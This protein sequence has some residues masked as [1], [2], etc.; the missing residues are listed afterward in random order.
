M[1]SFGG[2]FGVCLRFFFVGGFGFR[3]EGKEKVVFEL[4]FV[5]FGYACVFYFRFFFREGGR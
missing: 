1:W 4:N 5:I 3:G 2:R